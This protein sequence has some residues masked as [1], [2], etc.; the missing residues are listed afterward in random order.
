VSYC[1]E[2]A[3]RTSL[4]GISLLHADDGLSRLG[5]FGVSV[6]RSMDLI[7]S[8]DGTEPDGTDVYS[9]KLRSLKG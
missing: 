6:A 4:S 2:E 5:N 7:Y 9:S 8:P 1:R 3:D